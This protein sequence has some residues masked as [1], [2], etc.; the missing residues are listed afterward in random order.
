[1]PDSSR[2]APLRD[3]EVIT[4]GG[5]C[6]WCVEACLSRV[7]GVR[8]AIS[9]YAGGNV[10]TPTYEQVCSG[11]TGHTEVV[12][13]TFD[14]NVISARE[15]YGMFFS[16]HDPTTLNRQGHDIGSQYRSAVYC[17][18]PLQLRVVQEVINYVESEKLYGDKPVVTEVKMTSSDDINY[19]DEAPDASQASSKFNL[20]AQ[21]GRLGLPFFPAEGYHQGYFGENPGQGYCV[22]VVSPK[23]TKFRKQFLQFLKEDA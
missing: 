5:G 6:F 10:K 4:V 13:V 20:P 9:G 23:V 14:P 12:R 3:E 11:R 18:S 22:A 7:K 15:L 8:S 21:V 17:H 2:A 1:M 16:C 19:P